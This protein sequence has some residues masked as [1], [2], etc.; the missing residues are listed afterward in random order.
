MVVSVAVSAKVIQPTVCPVVHIGIFVVPLFTE[1]DALS[2]PSLSFA[3]ALK[4]ILFSY[5][6]LPV[7]LVTQLPPSQTLV[8]ILRQVIFT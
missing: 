6:I 4:V 7:G 5:A 1:I 2:I 3:L 8:G